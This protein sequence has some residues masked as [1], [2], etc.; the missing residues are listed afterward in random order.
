MG[1]VPVALR[2]CA[3]AIL[4][5]HLRDLAWMWMWT[6]RSL[7]LDSALSNHDREWVTR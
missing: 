1:R 5:H 7:A 2:R 6:L 4:E 3:E